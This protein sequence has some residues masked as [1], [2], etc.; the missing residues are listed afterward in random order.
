L[1]TSDPDISPVVESVT[2]TFGEDPT[3]VTL[4]A[5]SAEPSTA[6]AILS[7]TVVL[8]VIAGALVWVKRERARI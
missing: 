7:L 4:A 1:S 3:V 6:Q 2:A 8:L 5:F